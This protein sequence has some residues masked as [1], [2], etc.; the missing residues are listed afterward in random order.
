MDDHW[1]IEWAEFGMRELMAYLATYDRFERYCQ[2]RPY[3]W[4]V[5]GGCD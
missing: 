4:E 2:S 5:D 1:I 3:D